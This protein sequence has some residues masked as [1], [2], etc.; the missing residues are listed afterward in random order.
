MSGES[1]VYITNPLT[2][3][4][5]SATLA[6]TGSVSSVAGG[7]VGITGSQAT[8]SVS[9]S[10]SSVAG[11]SIGLTGS[12]AT[13]AVTGSLSLVSNV[14]GGSIGITGS[15]ATISVS[16]SLGSVNAT[17]ITGSLTDSLY[18][19]NNLTIDASSSTGSSNFD[20]SSYGTKSAY[21]YI[22][23]TQDASGSLVVSGSPNGTNYFQLRSGSFNSGSLFWF[24]IYDA[25]K[26]ISVNLY[27]SVTGSAISGSL[28]LVCQ[29]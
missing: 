28:F 22:G 7:S 29:A 2:I 15:Q 1:T 20:V 14:A 19:F 27:N 8:L 4:K 23:V 3:G 5:A 18:G 16:G 6:V 9:G 21:A 24:T 17:K 26:N 11:G 12:Q 10:L 13:L 25:I